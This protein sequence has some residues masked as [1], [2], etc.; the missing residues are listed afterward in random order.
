MLFAIGWA[1][2]QSS[3]A[4]Y[5]QLESPE[6]SDEQRSALED[7]L[8]EAS[9]MA[10]ANLFGELDA[11]LANFSA[12]DLDWKFVRQINNHSGILQFV[13]SRNHRGSEPTAVSILR[14]LAAKGP[15]SYG[16]V[17]LHDDEDHGQ[18]SIS[19][20]RDGE[21]HTAEFRVW[22]LVDGAVEELADPLLRGVRPWL[23]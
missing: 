3:R 14:W 4:G 6:L 1:V 16:L 15:S 22:R 20:G 7:S 2:A 11:L 13:S 5:R 17:Y 23:P 21:D 10:D 8:D 12:P 9:A 18:S 19:R